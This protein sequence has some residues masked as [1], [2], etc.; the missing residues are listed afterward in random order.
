MF[1]NRNVITVAAC[2]ALFSALSASAQTST[3]Y[4]CV[5]NKNG[6]LRIVSAGTACTAKEKDIHWSSGGSSLVWVDANGSVV[7]P[8]HGD[9]YAYATVDGFRL[10]LKLVPNQEE[11]DSLG[12]LSYRASLGYRR[13]LFFEQPGCIGQPYFATAGSIVIPGDERLVTALGPKTYIGRVEA[14]VVRVP[15]SYIPSSNG[16]CVDLGP[17]PGGFAIPADEA[18][19]DLDALFP[20]PLNLEWQ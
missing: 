18:S 14:P 7:G 12:T 5:D 6:S 16:Q 17:G 11:I 3:I 20:P 10:N 8:A 9:L 4:G 1:K 2:T 13:P 19:V 15:L